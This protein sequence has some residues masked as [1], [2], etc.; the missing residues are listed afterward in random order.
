DRAT[1]RGSSRWR[2]PGWPRQHGRVG[3]FSWSVSLAGRSL[4]ALRARPE[5]SGLQLVVEKL[6]DGMRTQGRDYLI[7]NLPHIACLLAYRGEAE[8]DQLSVIARFHFRGGDVELGAQPVED[9]A[10]HLSLVLQTL[11]PTDQQ[12]RFQR[13]N[14]HY[15]SVRWTFWM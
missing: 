10:N 12:A 7:Q 4:L 14:D 15:D 11:R 1:Q 6:G 3:G 2:P 8:D 5:G 9:A 13:A